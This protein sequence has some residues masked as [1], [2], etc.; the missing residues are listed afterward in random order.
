[1][2]IFSVFIEGNDYALVRVYWTNS[3]EMLGSMSNLYSFRLD[4][5]TKA[6]RKRIGLQIAKFIQQHG[7]G[8]SVVLLNSQYPRTLLWKQVKWAIEHRTL[9]N[10][11]AIEGQDVDQQ[12]K[13][14]V[15]KIRES[16]NRLLRGR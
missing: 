4:A 2:Q 13:R 7:D 6:P 10:L 5:R 3:H 12:V 11:R 16:Y 8:S 9:G 15:R 1:M 14:F